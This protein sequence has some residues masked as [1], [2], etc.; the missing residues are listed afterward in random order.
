MIMSFY[1]TLFSISVT[2]NFFSDD[3]CP[4]LEFV[5]TPSTAALVVNAG[6]LI[7]KTN[8]GINVSYDRD[9]IAT[10]QMFASDPDQPL[11]L[12]FKVF[13][14]D[15]LFTNYTQLHGGQS[16]SILYLDNQKVVA[17]AQGKLNLQ[18]GEYISRRDLISLDSPLLE[19]ILENKDRHIKPVLVLTITVSEKELQQINEIWDKSL[20]QYQLRFKARETFWIYY[21][22]GN[23]ANETASI[24]DLN[25]ETEFEYAGKAT[26]SE[27]RTA[28]TFRSKQAIPLQH[29][30]NYRFQLREKTAEGGKILIKRLPVASANQLYRENIAGEGAVVSEIYINY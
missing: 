20:L 24:V 15:S 9:H 6:L 13:S 23:L 19:S 28:E 7:R 8:D 29:R 30:T 14:N 18:A 25:N 22:F 17:D 2:H 1:Q 21:L 3:V 10:L 26:L 11:R 12:C 4:V 5:P 16:N 27:N